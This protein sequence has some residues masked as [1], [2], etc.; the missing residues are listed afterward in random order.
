MR[1]SS[2]LHIVRSF[3][4]RWLYSNGGYENTD[5]ITEKLSGQS[6]GRFLR[7]RI[8]N[9]LWHAWHNDQSIPGYGECRKGV[10]GSLQWHS[11]SP[12]EA[13]ASGLKL[14]AEAAGVQSNFRDLSAFYEN[15]DVARQQSHDGPLKDIPTTLSPHTFLEPEPS[16]QEI[17]Y[18][19][20]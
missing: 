4:A 13:K 9:P 6:W 15:M 19:L 11:M 3:R 20:G 18:G 7:E 8:L 1:F 16:L 2:Y 10:H 5:E 14:P 17:S 12:T